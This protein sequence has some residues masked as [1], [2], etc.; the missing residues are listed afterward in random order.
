MLFTTEFGMVEIVK[1]IPYPGVFTILASD[2]ETLKEFTKCTLAEIQMVPHHIYTHIIHVPEDNM[3][4]SFDWKNLRAVESVERLTPL[5]AAYV[6][7][8]VWQTDEEEDLSVEYSYCWPHQ[9]DQV[10]ESILQSD[11]AIEGGIA[12]MPVF[13]V[14]RELAK[15]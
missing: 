5:P 6:Y 4:S 2:A 1:E 12:F 8:Y 13:R 3:L 11:K 14:P 7:E 9:V 15:D 10:R